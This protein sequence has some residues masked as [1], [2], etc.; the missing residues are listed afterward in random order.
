[1][2]GG[3][4]IVRQPEKKAQPPEIVLQRSKHRTRSLNDQSEVA[5]SSLAVSSVLAALDPLHMTPSQEFDAF[6][7]PGMMKSRHAHSI[8]IGNGRRQ[9]ERKPSDESLRSKKSGKSAK[10]KSSN[11]MPASVTTSGYEVALSALSPLSHESK[12]KYSRTKSMPIPAALPLKKSNSQSRLLDVY[13]A[14]NAISTKLNGR[15]TP[16]AHIDR[17]DDDDDDL[18]GRVSRKASFRRRLTDGF[19]VSPTAS[20]SHHRRSPSL[21]SFTSFPTPSP[22]PSQ[23]TFSQSHNGRSD[24]RGGKI[25]SMYECRVVHLCEPPPGVS[26]RDLPFFTLRVNDVYEVLQEAGHPSLHADLPLYVDDG[27][28]CLLLCRNA[29]GAIGWALASFLVPVD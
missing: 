2:V 28:D 24:T 6:P 15:T 5:A 29:K 3:L 22:S 17:C 8:D 18:R 21:P 25:P 26:Y 13:D 10:S 20:R 16:P 11:G 14:V 7:G 1:M 23:S 19:K 4:N 27:E 12:P 9:I